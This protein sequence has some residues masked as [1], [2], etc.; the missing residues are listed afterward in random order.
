MDKLCRCKMIEPEEIGLLKTQYV[1]E[2]CL[3]DFSLSLLEH[4]ILAISKVYLDISLP[5]LARLLDIPHD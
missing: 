2:E 5:S 4:N 1:R 3:A